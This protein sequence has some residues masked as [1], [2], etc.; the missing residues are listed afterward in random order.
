MATKIA[1]AA[2]LFSRSKS[3]FKTARLAW[4]DIKKRAGIGAEF[5][6]TPDHSG[7]AWRFKVA[8]RAQAP[9][10]SSA[11]VAVKPKAKSRRSAPNNGRAVAR[12]E[13]GQSSP[14]VAVAI[15]VIG[16]GGFLIFRHRSEIKTRFLQAKR[17][18]VRRSRVPLQAAVTPVEVPTAAGQQDS[19]FRLPGGPA[20]FNSEPTS[21]EFP[22]DTFPPGDGFDVRIRPPIAEAGEIVAHT[23]I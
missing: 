13:S 17:A 22:K 12:P 16:V 2:R 11:K 18:R 23:S 5:A 3:R 9:E 20:T 19:P 10:T 6:S 1:E 21:F 8:P 4:A 14:A 15:A 7:S